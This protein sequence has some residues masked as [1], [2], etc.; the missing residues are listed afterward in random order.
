MEE[1]FLKPN[2]VVS[3]CLAGEKKRY[4][5]KLIKKTFFKN[6]KGY[7]RFIVFCP[8]TGIG[9][10]VP[11]DRTIL[12]RTS[13][14]IRAFYLG[15]GEDITQRVFSYYE[16][17]KKRHPQVDGLLLKAKSPSCGI[18][19]KTKTYAD[20]KGKILIG[21]FPGILRDKV[22]SDFYPLPIADEVMLKSSRDFFEDFFI[23]LFLASRFRYLIENDPVLA[24]KKLDL[25]FLAYTGKNFREINSLEEKSKLIFKLL[26]SSFNKKRFLNAMLHL[27]GRTKELKKGRK[28][29]AI[30]LSYKFVMGKLSFLRWCIKMKEV[31]G[32]RAGSVEGAWEFLHPYPEVLE[33]ER[34]LPDL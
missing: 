7:C 33:Y 25:F 22:L 1:L 11:R 9:L 4:D 32:E 31:L 23:K 21:R 18:S 24:F 15:T 13:S 3:G 26:S 30:Q 14:E 19:P 5:G 29:F 12:V 20:Q 10:P 2:L 16:N 28:N 8:E 27:I 6:L 17:F 34:C